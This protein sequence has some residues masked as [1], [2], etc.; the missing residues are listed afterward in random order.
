M[1]TGW[2]DL[3]MARQI[4]LESSRARSFGLR[5]GELCARR[6]DAHARAWV[7]AAF[8]AVWVALYLDMS[9]ISFW[10]RLF[11]S[12]V[13]TLL[14]LFVYGIACIMII[15][16]LPVLLLMLVSI[17][18]EAWWR[19]HVGRPYVPAPAPA[20]PALPPAPVVRR[21]GNWLLP[22]IIGFWIGNTWGGDD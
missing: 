1:T 17:G 12:G 14:I 5:F 8:I 22:L 7:T 2:G 19:T 11:A 20:K 21:H 16:M 3:T 13:A 6:A 4:Q 18:L 10:G 9:D 15:P